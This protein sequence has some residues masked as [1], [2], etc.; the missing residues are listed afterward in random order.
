M[1]Y[2]LRVTFAALSVLAASG[3]FTL[4]LRAENSGQF[5]AFAIGATVTLANGWLHWSARSAANRVVAK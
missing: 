1:L 2:V 3:L 5:Q 4:M